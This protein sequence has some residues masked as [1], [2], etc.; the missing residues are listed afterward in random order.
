[1][2]SRKRTFFYLKAPKPRMVYRRKSIEAHLVATRLAG[3]ASEDALFIAIDGIT[4]SC[5][6]EHTKDEIDCPPWKRMRK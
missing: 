5:Y 2:K 1:M 6:D 4:D 3:I